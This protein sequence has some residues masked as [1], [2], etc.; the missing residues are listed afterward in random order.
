MEKV[1]LT[2]IDNPFDPFT[3]WDDWYFYD[4]S[5][6]YNTCERLARLSITAEQL[7]DQ[8]NGDEIVYAM[9]QL[10]EIG[11]FN[12]KGEFIGYKKVIQSDSK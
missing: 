9:D 11:A 10:I 6:G 4:L 1:M 3:Q 2:T 7:P 8:V 5:Q 12:K